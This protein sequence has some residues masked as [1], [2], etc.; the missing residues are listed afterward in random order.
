ME[1]HVNLNKPPLHTL[2]PAGGN[3]NSYEF[4]RVELEGLVD[5]TGSQL[6]G[7]R[8]I[9]SYK[10]AANTDES[11]GGFLVLSPF[12]LAGSQEHV[13]VNRGWVP[14]DAGKNPVMLAQYI[15]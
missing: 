9:P 12:E 15:G 5:S 1:N 13:M 8:A 10:G 11:R 6:V 2:P 4:H 3:M 7:P 14:I